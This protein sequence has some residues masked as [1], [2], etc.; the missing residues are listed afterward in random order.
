M[1]HNTLRSRLF[2]DFLLT[3]CLCFLLFGGCDRVKTDRGNRNIIIDNQAFFI[4]YDMFDALYSSTVGLSG[5]VPSTGYYDNLLIPGTSISKYLLSND[6]DS[7]SWHCFCC[8]NLYLFLAF[9]AGAN[10]VDYPLARM[11]DYV[12]SD[13]VYEFEDFSSIKTGSHVNDVKKIDNSMEYKQRHVSPVFSGTTRHL[14]KEGL[15][16]IEWKDND[17]VRSISYEE[18]ELVQDLLQLISQ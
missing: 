10:D 6:S 18:N 5:P 16:V 9:N 7:Y 13:K 3:V 15:V 12:C 2:I 4:E 14:C 8:Q 1:K 11:V 17:T